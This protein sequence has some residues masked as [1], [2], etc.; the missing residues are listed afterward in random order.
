MQKN[1][2]L[3]LFLSFASTICAQQDKQF[4]LDELIPGGKSY[5][6]YY[7]RVSEQFYWQGDSLLQINGDSVFYVE[8]P[9]SSLKKS[10]FFVAVPIKNEQINCSTAK[11]IICRLPHSIK[12]TI[13]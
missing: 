10:S 13:F 8:K 4:T 2:L 12:R 6:K 3:I 9:F 5:Y 7:P 11:A 1:I